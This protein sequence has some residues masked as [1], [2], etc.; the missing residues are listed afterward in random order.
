MGRTSDGKEE[1]LKFVE[2]VKKVKLHDDQEAFSQIVKAL[3]NY[4]IHL[5]LRKFKIA[6]TNSDD[7]YQ[8]GLYALSTKAI[9]DYRED[10][11]AFICFAKLCIRRH[12]ITLLKSANN[13]KNKALNNN[14]LS[15]DAPAGHDEEEGTIPVSGFLSNGNEDLSHKFI[16][17]EEHTMLKKELIKKLTPLEREVFECYLKNMSYNEAVKYMNKRR[18]G[19]NRANA[20]KIDNSLCRAKCKAIKLL[21]ELKEKELEEKAKKNK[22]KNK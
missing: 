18:R 2:L 8:E 16:R 20:K 9:P 5:S 10:K 14:P 12:I 15:L 3:N 7:I 22:G 1:N 11:G 4:L 13:N 19:E 17:L 6:G 21:Q